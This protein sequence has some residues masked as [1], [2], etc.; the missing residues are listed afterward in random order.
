MEPAHPARSF[1]HYGGWL[2]DDWEV[3]AA[4]VETIGLLLAAG[5]SVQLLGRWARS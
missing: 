2:L 3:I 4:L 5:I 1:V